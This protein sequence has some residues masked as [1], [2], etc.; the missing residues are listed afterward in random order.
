[1]A[2]KITPNQTFLHEDVR[3]EEGVE[4]EVTP[5]VAAAAKSA[6]FVDDPTA[7]KAQDTL[8]LPV[9]LQPESATQGST[10]TESGKA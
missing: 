2:T 6:G 8:R 5:A 7:T 1:M 4:V 10:A 9:D 3:Y